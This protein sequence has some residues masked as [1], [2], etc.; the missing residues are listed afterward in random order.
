M[1][2]AIDRGDG[3]LHVIRSTG[4]VRLHIEIGTYCG[5]TADAAGIPV[6]QIPDVVFE[7]NRA[8]VHQGVKRMPCPRCRAAAFG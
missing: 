8:E 5:S 2:A 4:R 3:T 1:I 6:L 7:Q